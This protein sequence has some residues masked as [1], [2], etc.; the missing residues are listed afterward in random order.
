MPGKTMTQKSALFLFSIL[1]C[2]VC[3]IFN[4][5]YVSAQP[6]KI[7]VQFLKAD[8]YSAPVGY[9]KS[10]NCY[11]HGE[12]SYLQTVR[13]QIVKVNKAG[14]D[15]ILSEAKNSNFPSLYR[16]DLYKL[17]SF[18][19]Y[20]LHITFTIL[21]VQT[22]D[23]ADFICRVVDLNGD[24]IEDTVKLV[25]FKRPSEIFC[26]KK[27]IFNEVE[28]TCQSSVYP[29]GHC[30]VVQANHPDSISSNVMY[31]QYQEANGIYT[32]SCTV[33]ISRFGSNVYVVIYPDMKEGKNFTAYSEIISRASSVAYVTFTANKNYGDVTVDSGDDVDFKCKV[34]GSGVV[35]YGSVYFFKQSLSGDLMKLLVKNT[36]AKELEYEIDEMT[37]EHEGYYYCQ[38]G[39]DSDSQEKIRVRVKTCSAS[40]D[41]D[42]ENKYLQ[43]NLIIICVLVSAGGLA[44]I[45]GI[46]VCIF[47]CVRHHRRQRQPR[48]G[49]N[50]F[51][52]SVPTAPY[53]EEHV[54]MQVTE[55]EARFQISPPPYSVVCGKDSVPDEMP[56]PY[57]GL[58][59]KSGPETE[60]HHGLGPEVEVPPQYTRK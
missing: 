10:L 2:L 59:T 6:Q 39:Y 43:R 16:V 3:L 35:P 18:P 60:E 11:V 12:L 41:S 22:G 21:S 40:S 55:Q 9:S 49:N 33:Q 20:K 36:A 34:R 4:G 45:V 32:T 15:V 56:P 13:A 14:D 17:Y 24:V 29:K 37:C 23:D 50:G 27:N 53:P 25:V 54:Y 52:L 19:P 38:Y 7:Y 1:V 48:S 31:N 28:I 51:I 5:N 44:F 58:I 26:I 47:C 46:I 57:P 42:F 8:D 30:D